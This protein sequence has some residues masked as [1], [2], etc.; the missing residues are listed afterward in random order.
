MDAG[1]MR[2]AFEWVKQFDGVLA[3]HAQDATLADAKACAH[4]GE[5][6]GRLGLPGWP[7]IA[8]SIILARDVQLAEATGS[9]YHAMHVT[10]AE[11]VEVIRWAK[12]RGINVTA[13]ATPHHLLLTDEELQGYDTTYKVNPPLRSNEHVTALREALASGVI[14]VIG[15]DHAPHAAQDKDHAFAD[16]RPG[17]IGLE[18]AL[19]VVIETMVNP[20]LLDWQQVAAKMSQL[21]AKI[22]RV[23]GQ[24][25][26]L[27]AGEPA[28][29]VLV[30]PSR[31]AVVDK[32]ASASLSRNNPYHGRD[33]PD[34]VELTMWQGK[35]TYQ[36][37]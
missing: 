12:A 22:G 27:V 34:P 21:P 23:A 36:R 3:Q 35:V 31:R 9:R 33:L 25:R 29:L 10:T 7:P 6:S 17:M 19:G 30:N 11:G 13:E 1:L 32:N 8:E 18:Q 24:G 5:V 14:D 20:G 26:P 15:T 2:K 37:P 4:E 28:N 16:A